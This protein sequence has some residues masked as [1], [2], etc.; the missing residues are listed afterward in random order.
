MKKFT[1]NGCLDSPYTEE[2]FLKIIK[3]GDF[4]EQT[5]SHIREA[6][7]IGFCPKLYD[8]FSIL[9]ES[10][11][12]SVELFLF[13]IKEFDLDPLCLNNDGLNLIEAEIH[14]KNILNA[15]PIIKSYG[16]VLK[17][18]LCSRLHF[19]LLPLGIQKSLINKYNPGIDYEI[20]VAVKS[21]NIQ[22]YFKLLINGAN[23]VINDLNS[24]VYLNKNEKEFASSFYLD[25]KNYSHL[26][27][28]KNIQDSLDDWIDNEF[29]LEFNDAIENNDLTAKQYIKLQNILEA[30][31]ITPTCEHDLIVYRGLVIDKIPDYKI[32]ET[33]IFHRLTSTTNN[34]NYAV[35]GYGGSNCIFIMHLKPDYPFAL[36]FKGYKYFGDEILLSIDTKW[37]V[38]NIIKRT[39]PGTDEQI[40]FILSSISLNKHLIL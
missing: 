11:E 5:I 39:F 22:E 20:I 8:C 28:P 21:K 23:P 13:M 32:N 12:I 27:Y 35:E 31:N 15:L 30:I 6:V 7:K 1:K 33:I 24:P 29:Y 14:S 40:I 34:F 10:I 36:P 3:R 38:N 37:V 2:Y 18:K 25:I 19:S 17:I 26:E 9:K 4:I 16:F